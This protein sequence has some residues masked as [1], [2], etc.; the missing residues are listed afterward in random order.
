MIY[1]CFGN[2]IFLF[3]IHY[4][5]GIFLKKRYKYQSPTQNHLHLVNKPLFFADCFFLL[6][7]VLNLILTHESISFKNKLIELPIIII[8]TILCLGMIFIRFRTISL[9]NCFFR[10]NDHSLE[11][12]LKGGDP[13]CTVRLQTDEIENITYKNKVY[14][15]QTK[16]GNTFSIRIQRLDLFNGYGHILET[17]EK[18]REKS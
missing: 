12:N 3:I 4:Y 2:L 5:I 1:F 13:E 15:I 10:L 8:V 9:A 11:Y 18:L 7:I 16:N 14:V 17:L 6:L